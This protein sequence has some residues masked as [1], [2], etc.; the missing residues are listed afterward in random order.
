M[1]HMQLT[2]TFTRLVPVS[3]AARR[4]C[5]ILFHLHLDSVTE[6]LEEEN[7]E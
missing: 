1:S 5:K 6:K 7:K 3:S 4:A 2:D